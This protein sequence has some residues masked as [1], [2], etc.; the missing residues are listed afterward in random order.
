[1]NGSERMK[2]GR[3][4]YG[5]F[6][7]KLNRFVA[8]VYVKEELEKVHIKNTG[9]LKELLVPGAKVVLEVSN[10]PERK[11]KYS[12]IAVWKNKRIV[13][14]DSQAPN[15]VAYD[16]ILAGKIV[17]IGQVD[18]LRREVTYG[19]SRF[20]LYYEKGDERGF[21]EVKGV[22]LEEDG[23]AKFPDAPTV[24]GAK[25]VRELM[26]AVDNGY[27]AMILF[28]VQMRGCTYF[29]PNIEMDEAFSENLVK[30]SKLGVQVIA[31]DTDVEENELV[32]NETVRVILE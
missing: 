6:H 17:E 28:V 2:Y 24:R 4:V 30:S 8:E 11:T 18:V 10:N 26:N 21:I 31:Y 22:T 27:K 25:H 32:L 13:N 12:I 5:K 3:V 20:D 7:R 9:R 29:T 16:A 23:V 14:I 1:M 15:I 19:K